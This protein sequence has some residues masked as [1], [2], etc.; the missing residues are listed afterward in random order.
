MLPNTHTQS[1]HSQAALVGAESEG[2]T[3]P[4]LGS[5]VS[6]INSSDPTSAASHHG[7]HQYCFKWQLEKSIWVEGQKTEWEFHW[8]LCS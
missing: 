5:Q 6:S 8:D 7:C 2:E 1:A 4:R 3:S